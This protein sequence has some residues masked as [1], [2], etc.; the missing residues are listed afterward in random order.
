MAATPEVNITMLRVPLSVRFLHPLKRMVLHPTFRVILVQI[1]PA[2]K[3]HPKTTSHESFSVSITAGTGEVTISLTAEETKRLKPGRQVYD[4]LLTSGS[5][6]VSRL[7]SASAHRYLYINTQTYAVVRRSQS[8]IY[9]KE[10][11]SDRVS[12]VPPDNLQ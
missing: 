9:Q 4:V 11:G 7:V 3:K 2:I 12:V 5:G 6:S 10:K 8:G 1:T